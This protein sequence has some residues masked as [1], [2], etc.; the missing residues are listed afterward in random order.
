MMLLFA[1]LETAHGTHGPPVRSADGIKM[2]IQQTARTLREPT[3][4]ELWQEH[5][6]GK[7]PLGIVP[8]KTDGNCAWGSIDIDDYGINVLEIVEDVAKRR[9]PLVPCR[10]KSGGLHLFLFLQEPQPAAAVQAALREAAAALGFGGSEIFPKQTMILTERGDTGNWMVMPYFGDTYGGVIHE[11]V[12]LK[13]TGAAMTIQEFIAAAK[14]ASC[15]LSDVAFL[16]GP[17]RLP[18]AGVSENK[19]GEPEAF[20]DGP[21]CLQHLA[22]GGISPGNRN[23][24]LLMIG[25]YMK[26]SAGAS[27]KDAIEQANRKYLM[28]P[29][30]AEEVV[31]IVRSLDKKEYN[32]TC[33]AEPMRSHCIAA[34]CRTRRFG[35]GEPGSMPHIGGIS[36]L[37]TD[38]PLWFVSVNDTR[39]AVSTEQ[40][41][42]YKQFHRVLMDACNMCYGSMSQKDWLTVLGAAMQSVATT[43]AAPE[44]GLAGTI[45]ESLEEF[46][47]NRQRGERVEDILGGRPWEDQEAGRHYFRLR[48]FMKFLD[49]DH[50]RGVSK[51]RVVVEL[52]KLGGGA[53]NFIVKNK[54]VNVQWVPSSKFQHMPGSELPEAE[55]GDQI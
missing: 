33:K 9:V 15:H 27:W 29:L 31:N 37:E 25:I 46:L 35:V 41:Q 2:G 34:L 23:N 7:R 24:V 4:E 45:F 16:T 3:T 12:G 32:Y 18:G 21:P 40:L 43:K 10:S 1:G 20:S 30:G 47:T 55:E 50:V 6:E 8:I 38:P 49:Q 26:K 53:Y 51:T 28:P 36:K 48:D 22:R 54:K 19:G 42:D 5:I 39:I 14:Q 52:E 11:Q 17:K 44:V 13:P